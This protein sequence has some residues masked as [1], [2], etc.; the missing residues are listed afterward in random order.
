MKSRD[1][2]VEDWV[3]PECDVSVRPG[4]FRHASESPKSG[5]Q[6]LDIYFKSLGRNSHLLLNIP[7]HSL[8]ALFS[9]NS[10]RGGTQGDQFSPTVESTV[11]KWVA[12]LTGSFRRN[13]NILPPYCP[14]PNKTNL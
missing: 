14:G 13:V 6:V 11:W 4:R 9:A 5:R 1:A 12:K 10:I 2:A 8:I 7:P 3:A